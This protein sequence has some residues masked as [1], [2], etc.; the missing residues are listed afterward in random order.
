M[1]ALSAAWEIAETSPRRFAFVGALAGVALG[2][3][4]AG[5][6]LLGPDGH[7]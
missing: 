5:R 6:D 7:D 3:A 4:G 2:L 1:L